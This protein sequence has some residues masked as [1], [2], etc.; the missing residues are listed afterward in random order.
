MT[1]IQELLAE[2]AAQSVAIT[3]LVRALLKIVGADQG[4]DLRRDLLVKWEEAGHDTLDKTKLAGV[5]D[6]DHAILIERAKAK[7]TDIF[8]TAH[9]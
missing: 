1:D 4:S 3:T 7:L 9:S 2:Q 5:S 8:T 6:I